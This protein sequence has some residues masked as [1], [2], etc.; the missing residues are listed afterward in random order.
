MPLP[1]RPRHRTAVATFVG[2]ADEHPVELRIN[3]RA[4][5]RDAI[6]DALNG[7]GETFVSRS[8][9]HAGDIPEDTPRDW[10][11]HSI[12]LHHAGNSHSC[13]MPGLRQMHGIEKD[14]LLASSVG[15][16][17]HYAVDCRGAIFEGLDIR[18]RGEHLK[19][20]N[21]RHIGIVFLA[22]FSRNGEAASHAP[23]QPTTRDRLEILTDGA[24]FIYD[25]PTD[26]QVRGALSLCKTL[27]AVFPVT[28]LGGHTEFAAKLGDDRSCP[29]AFGLE[30]AR[31]LR[32]ELSLFAP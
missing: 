1:Y 32:L 17:Y 26:V 9:W 15:F 22:D 21:T 10:D 20:A 13:G 7:S 24:D 3:N 23:P 16:P 25:Q 4:A 18:F 30:I 12:V 27:Q 5:T 19:G 8:D 28:R 31:R 29:G 11:Y 14:H 6:I 2:G